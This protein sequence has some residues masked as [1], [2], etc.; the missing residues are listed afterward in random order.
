MFL[1]LNFIK[2]ITYVHC[3]RIISCV[4]TVRIWC[5]IFNSG[6]E[7]VEIQARSGRPTCTYRY[8][9]NIWIVLVTTKTISSTSLQEIRRRF[10]I[11]CKRDQMTWRHSK[12]SDP[13]KFK[14]TICSKKMMVSVFC[15]TRWN[16]LI[17][18]LYKRG[19]MNA[20]RYI[21]TLGEIKEKMRFKRSGR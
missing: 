17:E 10:V 6:R 3:Q 1:R 20:D 2:K 7:S 21:E 16:L 8:L 11:L 15:Y 5:K 19:T 4:I 12:S 9:S 13:K 18:F 14:Q